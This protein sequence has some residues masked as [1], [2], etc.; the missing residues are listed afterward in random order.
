M[1]LPAEDRAGRGFYRYANWEQQTRVLFA[2]MWHHHTSI[3]RYL[4]RHLP[5]A[6]GM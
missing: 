6:T 2:A 1:A 3:A 4:A 5:I